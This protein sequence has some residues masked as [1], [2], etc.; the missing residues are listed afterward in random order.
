MHAIKFTNFSNQLLTEFDVLKFCMVNFC[1]ILWA[2][3]FMHL[4]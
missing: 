4:R 2:Q 1:D 3:H